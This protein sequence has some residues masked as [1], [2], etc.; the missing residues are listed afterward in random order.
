MNE[1]QLIKLIK[2]RG[3]NYNNLN[4][5]NDKLYKDFRE[6]FSLDNLKNLKDEELLNTLF[7]GNVTEEGGEG[8]KNLSWCLEYDNELMDF[9]SIKGGDCYKYQ[10]FFS[11]DENSWVSGSRKKQ[12]KLSEKDAIEKGRKIRD[13]LIKVIE[14]IEGS[15]EENVFSN[16][17]EKVELKEFFN[18]WPWIKYYHMMFP[19]IFPTFYT[20]DKQ[21]EVLNFI[22]EKR[23]K[24]PLESLEEINE[25]REKTGLTN[26]VF[27]KVLLELC[28]ESQEKIYR[29]DNSKFQAENT[30][31]YGV[32]GS[33]KSWIIKKEYCNNKNNIERVVFHPDY[34]YSD[35]VGQILPKT[36]ND[37][38]IYEFVPG[39]F[40]KLLKNAY[41]NQNNEYF[42]II[43]EINRGNAPSIFGD[44]FQLLDRK[45]D[46]S[47]EYEITNA[48][49]AK[50]VYGDPDKK[51]SIPSN[52]SIICTMNTCDQNVFTLDTAFQRRWNMRLVKNKFDKNDNFEKKLAETKISDTE[53]T[54]EV[55]LTEINKCILSENIENTSTEDKRLGKHFISIN[56]LKQDKIFAEKV[57]KYLWDDA[58]KFVRKDIFRFENL[59]DV[60]DS[61]LENKKNDRFNIFQNEIIEKLSDEK[62]E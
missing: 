45:E 7:L 50:I 12:L 28:S 48:D 13:N 40:T 25:F 35:F 10:L 61:F 57:L 17:K 3:K 39:P 2:E 46:G 43:E 14:T 53:V 38:V 52:M 36:N 55:F 8:E 59:E 23:V 4:E 60:I 15:K 42:L 26:L 32:P 30:I 16:L 34:T 37:V 31:L 41:N 29:R 49:I 6:K 51:V 24:P 54:W 9:G 19:E 11:K 47:S 33:G 56:D 62:S 58:F 22:N 21:M 5:K 44:I 20:K 18:Q 27:G 1:K